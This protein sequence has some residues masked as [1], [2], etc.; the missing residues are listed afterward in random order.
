[1]T[2]HSDNNFNPSLNKVYVCNNSQ[3]LFASTQPDIYRRKGKRAFDLTLV[4]LASPF[5]LP[6]LG[7]L[8][9]LVALNG[10]RPF[11]SQKR[12]GRNGELYTM[13]KLR[14]MVADAEQELDR[15]LA[16]NPVARAEWDRTQKL[17]H[18]PRITAFGHFLRR[19]SMD[20]L[21]QLWNVLR[22]DM[23]IVGPRPMLP[24]Q[25]GMYSGQAYYSLRP[26]I[27]GNWQVSARNNSSFA[28]RADYDTIYGK[29]VSLAVDCSILTATVLVV[30][31][32][33]GH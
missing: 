19:S 22:G 8:A 29:D 4:I 26:G 25:I 27:T 28:E 5:V 6:I 16:T 30:L 13:W 23:S 33:T 18:D 9:L 1:M 24:S 17:K 7:I 32:A 3:N 2:T 20:E 11:Y 15:F 14:T 31:K 12:I 21:P 10:G